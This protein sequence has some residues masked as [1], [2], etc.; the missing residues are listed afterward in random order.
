MGFWGFCVFRGIL[1]SFRDSVVFWGILG[2]FGFW[3]ILGL[4]SEPLLSGLAECHRICWV[5]GGKQIIAWMG[6][7]VTGPIFPWSR[8]SQNG[9]MPFF[10]LGSIWRLLWHSFPFGSPP[11]TPHPIPPP[12]ATPT[13]LFSGYPSYCPT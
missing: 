9:D 12:S 11:L 13:L 2:I 1:G 4:V 8:L 6:P 5:G 7:K 10:T 3:R